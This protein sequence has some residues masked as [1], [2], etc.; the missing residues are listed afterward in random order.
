MASGDVLPSAVELTG[1]SCVIP[2]I[3]SVIGLPSGSV[4]PA[5]WPATYLWFGG[6]SVPS[7]VVAA[8]QTG[9]W[10]ILVVT[11]AVLFA[12]FGSAWSPATVAMFTIDAP[13]PASRVIV[14]AWLP[15][16][17]SVPAVQVIR[18]AA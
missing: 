11:V 17:A 12:G 15:P 1:S 2:V 5:I 18:P 8:V 4:T 3:V 16:G 10:L 7:P 13:E 9:L 14:N 6:Q